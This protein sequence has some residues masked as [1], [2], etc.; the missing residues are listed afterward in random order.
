MVRRDRRKKDKEEKLE[1]NYEGFLLIFTFIFH[2]GW[3]LG[4]V[5]Y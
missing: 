3:V 5:L 4:D 1:R 2:R